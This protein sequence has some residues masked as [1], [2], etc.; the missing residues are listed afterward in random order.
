MERRT[1][2]KDVFFS[3]FFLHSCGVGVGVVTFFFI[4]V[5]ISPFHRK[6]LGQQDYEG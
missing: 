1:G 4:P 5:G 6:T 3:F 2:D